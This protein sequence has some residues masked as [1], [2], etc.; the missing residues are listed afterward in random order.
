MHKDEHTLEHRVELLRKR[1]Q[2]FR[3]NYPEIFSTAS[4]PS[5]TPIT[6]AVAKTT[7]QDKLNMFNVHGVKQ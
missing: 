4:K 2:Q 1:M 7:M 5:T 3:L 6:G